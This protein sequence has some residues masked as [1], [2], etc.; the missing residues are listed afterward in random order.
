MKYPVRECQELSGDGVC[1]G[2][3]KWG[4]VFPQGILNILRMGIW[5]TECIDSGHNWMKFGSIYR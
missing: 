5:I 3:V 1:V 4:Q 2:R